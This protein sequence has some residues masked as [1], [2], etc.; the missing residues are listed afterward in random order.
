MLIA[1]AYNQYAHVHVYT[2][3]D[4]YADDH[5]DADDYANAESYIDGAQVREELAKSDQREVDSGTEISGN[6]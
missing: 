4:A 6:S 1:I 5:A 3:S 2:H